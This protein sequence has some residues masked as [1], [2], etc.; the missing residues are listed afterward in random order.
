MNYRSLG[1]TGVKVSPICLGTMTFGGRTPE[2][3]AINMVDVAYEAGINF[4]DTANIYG[5]GVSETI[6]G[7]AL[8]QNQ[9]RQ[10]IIVATKVNAQMADD[11]NSGGLSRRHIIAACEASL[12]RLQ[13]DYIDLYQIHS[14]SV[15]VPIDETLR[16]LDT[17]VQ[18]GKVRYIGCSNIR[19]WQVVESL[20]AASR[21]NTHRFV[22]IQPAYNMLDRILEREMFPMAETYGLA[23]LPWAP[24]SG[25]FL[26]GKY[27]KSTPHP[28]D[29]RLIH[30]D[31]NPFYRQ[32]DFE[33]A[34][35][36]VD[37]LD[38]MSQEKECT[39]AQLALAWCMEQPGVTSPI[40][41]VRTLEQL[42]SNIKAI[43]VDITDKDR[44]RID[45]VAPA[46]DSLVSYELN[47]RQYAPHVH[48]W[49]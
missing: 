33:K 41:G 34:Y 45:K 44:A 11:P 49:G 2:K 8:K 23:I 15:N 48:R 18:D 25:G 16:A 6:L 36:V 20:W 22:S 9:K 46:F 21:L 4:M 1:R 43:D 10:N 29:S 19:S 28:E 37:L 3:E 27:R 17:L 35:A 31:A 47:F 38:E 30:P 32:L 24:L 7:K 13:T 5:R 26:T 39:I 14:S 42:E 12:K 40:I